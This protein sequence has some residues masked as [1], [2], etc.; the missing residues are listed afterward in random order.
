M[1]FTKYEK[2]FHEAQ[3]LTRP[4]KSI[5]Y[6]NELAEL[7]QNGQ[8][9]RCKDWATL[10]F[11]EE[12]MNSYKRKAWIC[13]VSTCLKVLVQNGYVIRKEDIDLSDLMRYTET[14]YLWDVGIE[15]F[16]RDK[17]AESDEN[18]CIWKENPEYAARV[19]VV[20]KMG[21]GMAVSEFHRLFPVRAYSIA[22]IKYPRVPFFSWKSETV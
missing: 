12:E 18:E 22:T 8:S 16:I 2:M 19:E 17:D 9:L 13:R 6:I 21:N 5:N 7:M 14:H 10:L 11:G 4:C 20:R 15:P 3:N 1:Q